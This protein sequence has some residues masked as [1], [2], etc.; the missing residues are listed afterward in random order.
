MFFGCAGSQLWHMRSALWRVRSVVGARGPGCSTV[1][2]IKPASP[3]LHSG[4][5]ATRPSGKS[6]NN[7]FE[8]LVF[9]INMSFLWTYLKAM[10]HLFGV[11][12]HF[13]KCTICAY[14]KYL[15]PRISETYIFFQ[16]LCSGFVCSLLEK[17]SC[18]LIFSSDCKVPLFKM[19]SNSQCNSG[20]MVLNV[21]NNA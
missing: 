17:N 18:H 20:S 4:F 21:T 12:G 3:A 16:S 2:G 11:T 5:P 15:I 9:Y 14:L 6:L 7:G 1:R 10:F 19:C 13:L 8:S